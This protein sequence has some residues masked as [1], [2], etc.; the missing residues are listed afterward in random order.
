MSL[1][2]LF[3]NKVTFRGCGWAWLLREHDSAEYKL[4]TGGIS[5]DSCEMSP[6]VVSSFSWVTGNTVL[7]GG[8]RWLRKNLSA[9]MKIQGVDPRVLSPNT[10]KH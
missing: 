10:L 6:K 8:C 9:F 7:T 1:K 4:S 5:G 3:S 2:T